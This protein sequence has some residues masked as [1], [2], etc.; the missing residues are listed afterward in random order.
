MASGSAVNS[1]RHCFKSLSRFQISSRQ[2]KTLPAPDLRTRSGQC[3]G[4]IIMEWVWYCEK[5]G[6]KKTNHLWSTKLLGY[7]VEGMGQLGSPSSTLRYTVFPGHVA[8]QEKAKQAQNTALALACLP[9]CLPPLV[10]PDSGHMPVQHR[11][12]D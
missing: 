9:V 11:R 2:G 6:G 12:R 1:N 7:A 8:S 3:L 5:H 10:L 4:M